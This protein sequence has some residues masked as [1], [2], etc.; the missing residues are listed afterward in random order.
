MTDAEIAAVLAEAD[1]RDRERRL[2]R[3][4]ELR[5]LDANA[6]AII[7]LE[8]QLN[9]ARTYRAEL[10]RRS[11]AAGLSRAHTAEAAGITPRRL[12]AIRSASA[13]HSRRREPGS[14]DVDA[15]R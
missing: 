13:K 14:S 4:A 5:A 7:Q 2:S 1:R 3:S 9:D 8:H 12:D 6:K 10:I 15:R 11:L